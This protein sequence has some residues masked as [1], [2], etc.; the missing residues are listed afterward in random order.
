MKWASRANGHEAFTGRL[1]R[2]TTLPALLIALV[3]ASANA[4]LVHEYE[5]DERPISSKA[6]AKDAA[7]S[8]DGTYNGDVASTTGLSGNAAHFDGNEDGVFLSSYGL[9]HGL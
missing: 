7:G 9:V 3:A 5:L 4:S 8:I 6:A 1:T 2:T